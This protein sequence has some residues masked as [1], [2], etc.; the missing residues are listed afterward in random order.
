MYQSVF[1]SN[2]AGLSI[3]LVAAIL[4]I[5]RGWHVIQN[6]SIGSGNCGPWLFPPEIRVGS[7]GECADICLKRLPSCVSVVWDAK[8]YHGEHTCA[9]HCKL[10]GNKTADGMQSIVVRPG[11]A[12]LCGV[13]P[14]PSPAYLT[15]KIHFV[16][17]V[18]NNGGWHDIAGAITHN[19]VHHIYQGPGW[20]HA[21]STDLV[22]E[23]QKYV[24]G[25]FFEYHFIIVF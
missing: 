7:A 8:G 22:R 4:S 11:N 9:F 21:M 20:N 24:R 13:P 5:A 6:Y 25:F 3:C 16:K 17:A 23:Y 15:P 1:Q 14:P 2:L 18:Y 19:G 12:S 10:E